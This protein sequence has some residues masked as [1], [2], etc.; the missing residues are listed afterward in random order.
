[1]NIILKI[2]IILA[3]VIVFGIA[4][5]LFFQ[6]PIGTQKKKI[7][8][9][10]LLAVTEAERELGSGTGQLKLRAVYSEFISVFKIA[11][12]F[13]SF[14]TF[15]EWVDDV[16]VKM[17]NILSTNKAVESLVYQSEPQTIP[18]FIEE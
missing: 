18:D 15:S 6:L 12:A 8:E 5:Y 4:V 16:L 9:W 2:L 13:I 1:M 11:A 10:L 7:K 3:V 14:E 17:R